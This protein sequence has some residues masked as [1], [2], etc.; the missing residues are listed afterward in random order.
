[1]LRDFNIIGGNA[2]RSSNVETNAAVFRS[3]V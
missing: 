1:M 2:A 3:E